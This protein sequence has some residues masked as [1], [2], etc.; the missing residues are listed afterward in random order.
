M[1]TVTGREK[2][3]YKNNEEIAAVCVFFFDGKKNKGKRRSVLFSAKNKKFFQRVTSV[4]CQKF[5]IKKV[6]KE[7]VFSFVDNLAF[8][9]FLESKKNLWEDKIEER[10]TQ[11]QNYKSKKNCDSL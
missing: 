6:F 7:K 9:F 11:R 2:K 3:I 5:Y 1:N 10:I 8:S 4:F